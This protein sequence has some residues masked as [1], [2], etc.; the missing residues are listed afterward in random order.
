MSRK[1]LSV[2]LTII[3]LA[4]LLYPLIARLIT[5]Y[6]GT[7]AVLN[8]QKNIS[9][10]SQN[11]K[12]KQL[13]NAQKYNKDLKTVVVKEEDKVGYV[14]Y[15]ETLNIDKAMGY[16]NIPK[17]NV[18]LT[19]YHGTGDSVLEV[20]I[21]H[22]ENTSLPVGGEGTH[23]VLTGH[24]GLVKQ[25]L[26]DDIHKLE[27][28]DKFYIYVLDQKLTYE[29]DQIKVVEP[30]DESDLKIVEGQDYVTLVTCT[31]YGV[32][33]HR[34][35]VRG[36][37]V[38]NEDEQAQNKATSSIESRTEVVTIDDKKN[39]NNILEKFKIYSLVISIII[40]VLVVAIILINSRKRKRKNMKLEK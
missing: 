17:I 27:I 39:I 6:N 19:I 11:D 28:K 40:I 34:L 30:S 9:N 33:S 3:G 31:P 32:N 7:E 21:G 24:T 29:V 10:A 38:P 16:I 12:E 13:E 22:L 2:I 14:N 15:L 35:L 18:Y 36:K 5:K 25:K 8:Y 23:A 20:G 1:K 4:I 26:F 37:R